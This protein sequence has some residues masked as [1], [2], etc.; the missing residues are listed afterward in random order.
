MVYSKW[1]AEESLKKELFTEAKK[2]VKGSRQ[3]NI[4]SPR[5]HNSGELSPPLGLK[6]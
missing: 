5:T 6:R 4:L 2:R 3:R 1:V